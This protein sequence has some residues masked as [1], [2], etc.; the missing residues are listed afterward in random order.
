MFRF[1]LYWLL[2]PLLV[3]V[4]VFLPSELWDESLVCSI[5]IV[6]FLRV[7]VS[8]HYSWILN[9]ATIIWGLEALNK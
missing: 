4:T 1:R 9:A 2:A 6:G 7:T 5:F 3:M 8:L